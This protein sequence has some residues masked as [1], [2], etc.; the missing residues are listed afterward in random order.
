MNAAP[1]FKEVGVERAF[2][3]EFRKFLAEARIGVL[4]V[5]FA[6]QSSTNDLYEILHCGRSAGPS[7]LRRLFGLAELRAAP[8]WR[9]RLFLAYLRDAY[10]ACWMEMLV[11]QPSEAQREDR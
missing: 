10:P 11:G 3:K 7:D 1:L 9:K 4:R 5:A 8:E 6:T 2:A